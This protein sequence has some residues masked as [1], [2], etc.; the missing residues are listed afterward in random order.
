MV[1]GVEIAKWS[2]CCC[3]TLSEAEIKLFPGVGG[4]VQTLLSLVVVVV[5]G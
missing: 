2:C 1:G 4:E 5:I 3:W